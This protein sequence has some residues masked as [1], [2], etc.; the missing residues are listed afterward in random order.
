M[1][2]TE[3]VK[4]NYPTTKREA[5]AVG[6]KESTGKTWLCVVVVVVQ[7][8]LHARSNLAVSWTAKG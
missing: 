4:E 6:G 7:G 3:A 2:E 1:K 5:L 8:V